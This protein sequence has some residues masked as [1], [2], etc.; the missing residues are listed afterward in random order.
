MVFD[1]PKSLKA[2]HE[3]LHGKLTE[4]TKE[5]GRTGEAAKAV[6]KILYPHFMKE[7]EYAL[8]PLS[9]LPSLAED[10]VSSDMMSILR[11]TDKLKS[12]IHQLFEEHSEHQD[13]PVP[14]NGIN[15][16][17]CH[18]L[19]LPEDEKKMMLLQKN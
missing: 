14:D 8:P 17:N 2:E 3:Y 7:E 18:N 15:C 6:V 5:G 1:I 10:R 4:A 19:Y 11:L 9:I 12:E 13:Y 16:C